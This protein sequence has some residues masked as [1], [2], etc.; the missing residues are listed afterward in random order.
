MIFSATQVS[1]FEDCPRKWSFRYIEGIETPP[2]PSAVL[3][4][5]VHAALEGWLRNATAPDFTTRAGSI[6]ASGLHLLPEP[7]TPGLEIEQEFH[8]EMGGFAFRGFIDWRIL[9]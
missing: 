6:A 3:G 2:H 4:T 5:E 9:G 1:V 7:R 8:L